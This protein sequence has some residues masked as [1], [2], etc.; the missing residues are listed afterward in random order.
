[1][2]IL[3]PL[4]LLAG[5]LGII[6]V[7]AAKKDDASARAISRLQTMVRDATSERDRLKTENATITAE[8][9]KVKQE[10]E[11]EKSAKLDLEDKLNHEA[12]AHKLSAEQ[13]KTHL[14]STTAKLRE[15]IEKYNALNKSKN[16]LVAEHSKL[17]NEHQFVSSELKACAHKNV[18]MF[19]GATE[20]IDAYE[21][22][23]NK[24]M[25]EALVDAE[26]VTQIK[27]V[28]FETI[29]QEY[30]DKLRKERFRSAVENK[31]KQ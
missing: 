6:P 15:V 21:R 13:S 31:G 2:R 24:S 11:Q 23:Q 10:L 29:I 3:L 18:K 27:N 4:M 26:P 16:E 19:E 28:E 9:D 17:Q 22:C 14:D 25:F 20:I 7:H 5:L 8:L 1:M 12:A 30:E